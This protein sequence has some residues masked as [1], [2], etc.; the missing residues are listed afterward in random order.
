MEG[1][2]MEEPWW[3]FLEP[4]GLV[5]D[6]EKMTFD[7]KD[8]KIHIERMHDGSSVVIKSPWYKEKYTVKAKDTSYEMEFKNEMPGLE[9]MNKMRFKQA[10]FNKNEKVADPNCTN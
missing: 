3:A 1:E 8:P 5:V 10:Q 2:V 6:E 9:V 7:M 4:Y